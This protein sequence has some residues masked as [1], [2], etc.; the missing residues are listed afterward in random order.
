MLTLEGQ[1]CSPGGCCPLWMLVAKSIFSLRMNACNFKTSVVFGFATSIPFAAPEGSAL[2]HL[3]KY[4]RPGEA[5]EPEGS[6]Q[7]L[8][9]LMDLLQTNPFDQTAPQYARSAEANLLFPTSFTPDVLD[10]AVNNFA[11]W[12]KIG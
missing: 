1:T 2:V 7:D 11:S 9:A 5:A 3:M 12:A 10:L 8:E 6:R 4:L